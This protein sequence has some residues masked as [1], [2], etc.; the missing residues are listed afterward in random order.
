ML[1]SYRCYLSSYR[2]ITIELLCW[3][4]RR[5]SNLCQLVR[6]NEF[7]TL[8]MASLIWV[9]WTSRR[10]PRCGLL[11]C[12]S[13]II[14]QRLPQFLFYHG[15]VL[16]SFRDGK[17]ACQGSLLLM[18]LFLSS[19]RHLSGH[20]TH[21]AIILWSFCAAEC[22]AHLVH[23]L[24]ALHDWLAGGPRCALLPSA[25]PLLT[26]GRA[27]HGTSEEVLSRADLWA[28]FATLYKSPA[29]LW[30]S[31]TKTVAQSCC[32]HLDSN[33]IYFICI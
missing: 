7:L 22:R 15:A 6:I 21:W 8:L 20:G 31:R 32:I 27:E 5:H 33:K 29:F 10:L 19:V 14:L 17:I 26:R 30:R 12:E 13:E 24:L 11:L 23:V 25:M 2:C 16:T 3:I 1:H 4:G 9:R 18:T 28:R